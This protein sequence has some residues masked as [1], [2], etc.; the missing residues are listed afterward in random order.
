VNT[1]TQ[2][3][4]K[5]AD[6]LPNVGNNVEQMWASLDEDIMDD[7]SEED[8]LKI[9]DNNEYVTDQALGLSGHNQKQQLLFNTLKELEEGEYLLLVGN[10]SVC[11][12][13]LEGVQEQARMLAFG[14]HPL[15]QG[16]LASIDDLLIVKRVKIKIGVFLE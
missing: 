2:S 11:S 16:S 8:K 12:G 13:T 5:P 14:E 4:N 7:L 15:C 10:T 1:H 3:A 6:T 9:I